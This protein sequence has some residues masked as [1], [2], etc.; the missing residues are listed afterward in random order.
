MY[1]CVIYVNSKDQLERSY[2]NETRENNKQ[3]SGNES[4]K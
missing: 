4:G 3:L 1:N 2:W